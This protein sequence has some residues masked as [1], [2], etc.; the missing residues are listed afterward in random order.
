MELL[1]TRRPL[2]ALWLHQAESMT[3]FY[4]KKWKLAI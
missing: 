3:V 1:N 4:I 2:D